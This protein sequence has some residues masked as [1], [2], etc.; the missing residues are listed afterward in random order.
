MDLECGRGMLRQSYKVTEGLQIYWY[1]KQANFLISEIRS[2]INI[3]SW[4]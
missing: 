3:D 1:V 4:L 2:C